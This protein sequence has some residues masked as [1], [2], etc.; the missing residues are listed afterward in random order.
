MRLLLHAALLL[1]LHNSLVRFVQVSQMAALELD[2]FV[3]GRHLLRIGFAF[4][5]GG[6]PEIQIDAG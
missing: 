6:L 3:R 2:F 5:A 4:G 1:K